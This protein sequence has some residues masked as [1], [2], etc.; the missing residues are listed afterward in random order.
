MNVIA[1]CDRSRYRDGAIAQH[2]FSSCAGGRKMDRMEAI[3]TPAFWS[4][5]AAIMVIN[6]ALSGDNAIVIA[7]AARNLEKRHQTQ[8]IIWGTFGAVAVR[9]VL[10]VA[11]V[12]L[13]MVPGLNLVG[14][15][16]LVWIAYDLVAGDNGADGKVPAASTLW[17]AMRTIMIADAAMG[18][19]NVLA[20]AGAAEGNI[21]LVVLGLVISIPIVVWGSTLILKS[22]ERF[23]WLVYVGGAVLAWTAA[24]M[25]TE[26][27]FVREALVGRPLAISAAYVALIGGILLL[28]WLRNRRTAL[29]SQ[30]EALQ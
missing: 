12:W 24:K 14:G 6:I 2:Q 21:T 15:I 5:L 4:S 20:V 11:V 23:P 27:P 22:I 3:F 16:V 29:R 7:F 26:E 25:I 1:V 13:L 10:T 17:G 8:A 9:I 19:D 28:A 18:M 30:V